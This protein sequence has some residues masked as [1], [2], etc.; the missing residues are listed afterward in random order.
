MYRASIYCVA[1]AHSRHGSVDTVVR[2]LMAIVLVIVFIQLP[3]EATARTET[4]AKAIRLT[5]PE[6]A[7][8]EAARR[9]A[10]ASYITGIVAED[11][12]S[13]GSQWGAARTLRAEVITTLV[14]R[15]NPA[16]QVRPTGVRILGARIIGQ[17]DFTEAS[18]KFPLSIEH[19]FIYE[20]V[21]LRNASS[22]SIS[23]AGT[24]IAGVEGAFLVSLPTERVSLMADGL[25]ADGSLVINGG[26]RA[27]G[28]VSLIQA[29]IKGNLDCSGGSMDN[30]GGVA[31]NADRAEVA[32][33]VGLNQKFTAKGAVN[34]VDARIGGTLFATGAAIENPGGYALNEAGA[35]ITGDVRLDNDDALD[36]NFAAKGIVNL[37]DAEIGRDLTC[38]GGSF[39][40]PGD[41]GLEACYVKVRGNVLLDKGFRATGSVC[42]AGAA[43]SGNLDCRGGKFHEGRASN[44]SAIDLVEASIT[45]TLYLS[46]LVPDGIVDLSYAK[47]RMLSDDRDSWPIQDALKL[48]GF[49]Y[50]QIDPQSPTD[51]RSRLQWLALQR[52]DNFSSQPYEQLAK[53]LRGMGDEADARDPVCR[54][55]SSPYTRKSRNRGLDLELDSLPIDRLWLPNVVLPNLGIYNYGK[56]GVYL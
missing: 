22:R 43:I 50:D 32:D 42:L 9:G 29:K 51:A 7:L 28:G 41:G 46:D 48:E 19:S 34:L 21:V 52:M 16:W 15:T 1:N 23:L 17:L 30:P 2:Y 33:Y 3:N 13:S 20:P 56:W 14:T 47:A 37:R 31:L 35:N 40:N 11:I 24:Y 44:S 6:R 53:A 25:Q 49:T 39:D 54:A 45:G 55:Q 10:V 26:F 18:L 27:K 4:E 38:T 36:R 8:I 12:P 5:K